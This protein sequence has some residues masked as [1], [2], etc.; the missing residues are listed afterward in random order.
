MPVF[1]SDQRG[2]VLKTPYLQQLLSEKAHGFNR[3]TRA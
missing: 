2:Y 3:G 1:K